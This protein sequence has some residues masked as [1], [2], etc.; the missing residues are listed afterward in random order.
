MK[1]L[2]FI[3]SLLCTAQF[4]SAQ[5]EVIFS[6]YQFNPSLIN[7]A[8]SGFYDVHQ[9]NFNYRDSWTGF[10]GSP[11]TLGFNYNGPVGKV[12]G[13]GAGLRTENAASLSRYRINLNFA[14]KYQMEKLRVAGGFSTE[15]QQMR[16]DNGI[17]AR[18]SLIDIN[19]PIVSDYMDGQMFFD[20]NFGL[21][22]EY[23]NATFIG[24]SF[25]NLILAKL[26]DIGGAG[27]EGSRLLQYYM[28]HFGHKFIANETFT[29]T[30]SMLIKS[31]RNVGF[32]VDFNLRGDFLDEKLSAGVSYRTGLGPSLGL[33]LGTKISA[34]RLFY[35]YDVYLDEF[36][37]YNTGSHEITL[38]FEFDTRNRDRAAKFR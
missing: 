33:M 21:F 10:E 11:R 5:D 20:A 38:S 22:A 37:Q 12:F 24:L 26:D 17:M 27:T 30:P 32:N 7:P 14:F 19:D 28:F 25:P 31:V 15:I 1:K 23:N 35:S 4:V 29:L 2:L 3:F 9:L 6:H 36:Q 13:F 34:L 16:L 18:P 8:A